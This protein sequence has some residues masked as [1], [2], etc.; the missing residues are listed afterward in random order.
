MQSEQ[1]RS[2]IYSISDVPDKYRTSHAQLLLSV[3][4]MQKS[5]D[6][7]LTSLKYLHEA[8]ISY[9]HQTL[10][11][12]NAPDSVYLGTMKLMHKDQ[13]ALLHVDMARASFRETQA[14]SRTMVDNFELF[15][16]MSNGDFGT[17]NHKFFLNAMSEL[18]VDESCWC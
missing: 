13:V 11:L 3:D 7:L 17:M 9:G 14:Y 1:I 6:S 5:I 18:A 2:E 12:L 8:G 10:W 15:M 16:Q 4:A